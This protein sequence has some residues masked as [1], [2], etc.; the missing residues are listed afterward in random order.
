MRLKLKMPIGIG[1]C[2]LI[3]ILIALTTASIMGLTLITSYR[4]SKLTQKSI[5]ATQDYYQAEARANAILL[6]IGEI[7]DIYYTAS[8]ARGDILEKALAEI[9]NITKIE[10]GEI[11]YIYYE[12]PINESQIIEVIIEIELKDNDVVTLEK[13]LDE[14]SMPSEGIVDAIEVEESVTE[15]EESHQ[16]ETMTIEESWASSLPKSTKQ[17]L[18]ATESGA[19]L[20]VTS[21]KVKKE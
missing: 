4:D 10:L 7:Y 18:F 1:I 8:S 6:E 14:G 16:D 5:E 21:W 19:T 12:V 15:L 2:T 11:S 3:L 20:C 9:T 13:Q 17:S